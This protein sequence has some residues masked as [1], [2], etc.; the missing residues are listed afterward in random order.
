M[1]LSAMGRNDWELLL[2][3][4][5]PPVAGII[6]LALG[7]EVIHHDGT[8]LSLSARGVML[9]SWTV[10]SRNRHDLHVF[11][12]ALKNKLLRLLG[13]ILGLVVPYASGVTV[14]SC[15][16]LIKRVVSPGLA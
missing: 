13:R 5:V 15:C 16:R 8:S 9:K 14:G 10:S 7:H 3:Y 11:K 6:A 1:T 2:T 4:P 12:T